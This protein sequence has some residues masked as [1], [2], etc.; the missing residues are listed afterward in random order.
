VVRP[1][2][3][4]LLLVPGMTA[5]LCTTAPRR[6]RLGLLLAAALLAT[7][8]T[9]CTD[10][11]PWLS[12]RDADGPV[13]QPRESWDWSTSTGGAAVAPPGSVSFPHVFSVRLEGEEPQGDGT[14]PAPVHGG[15]LEIIDGSSCRMRVPLR[16]AGGACE[17]ELELTTEGICLVRARATSADGDALGACWYRALVTDDG[18]GVEAQLDALSRAAD[19]MQA[20]CED[21]L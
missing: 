8:A 10:D 11:G 21:D 16:C 12:V 20:A 2:A 5:T 3:R 4:G 13:D 6:A 15:S 1:V 17:A 9:G 18:S 19:A 14:G 7:G